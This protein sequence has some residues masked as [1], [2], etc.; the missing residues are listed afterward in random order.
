MSIEPSVQV[1]DDEE[2]DMLIYEDDPAIVELEGHI[3]EQE[4]ECE[5]EEKL[6]H[7]FER[8]QSLTG[9]TQYNSSGGCNIFPETRISTDTTRA[10]PERHISPD[11]PV[12][13]VP[14]ISPDPHVSPDPRISPVPPISPDSLLQTDDIIERLQM[15]MANLRRQS[16]DAITLS[17]RLSDQL[18]RAQSE[19]AQAQSALEL[20]EMK[21]REE[22]KKRMQAEREAD[23]AVRLRHAAEEALKSVRFH[24]ELPRHTP[25]PA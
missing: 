6:L 23:D 15:E 3:S 25:R 10:S 12:S 22:T 8:R 13:P 11:P 5:S 18:A 7:P 14:R 1:D 20:T 4:D 21:L 16:A 9:L 24:S 17:I 2:V 19:T